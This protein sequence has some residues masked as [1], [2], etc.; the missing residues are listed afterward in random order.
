MTDTSRAAARPIAPAPRGLG[1]WLI[2]LA[3]VF[4]WN[5]L[6]LNLALLIALLRAGKNALDAVTVAGDMLLNAWVL[7]L[8]FTRHHWFPRVALVLLAVRAVMKLVLVAAAMV[9]A[10]AS[11]VSA[12]GQAAIPIL[13]MLYLQRSRRVKATFTVRWHT[14][15]TPAGGANP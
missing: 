14:P 7:V 1:G 4:I 2:A 15:Q 13:W 10:N 9:N 12:L 8:F 3:G 6:I 5:G 11:I